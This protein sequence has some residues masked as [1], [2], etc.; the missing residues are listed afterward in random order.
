MKNI[1][2]AITNNYSNIEINQTMILSVLIVTLILSIYE[3]VVYR[4]ISHRSFYNKSF[5][6]CITILPL[7]LSTIIMCLQ[8]NII[9]TLGTIGALA[10]IRFRT[11]IK[12]PVDMLY[13]LW[14]IHIGITCGCRLYEVAFL[15]SIVVTIALVIL[16]RVTLGR[17][18]YIIVMHSSDE[19][20]IDK[21]IGKSTKRYRVKSRNYTSKGIDYTIEISTKN[22]NILL[23]SIKNEKN[24][25]KFSIIEY[26]ASDIL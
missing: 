20:E 19:V 4:Y 8:S 21:V 7:F 26:D 10:I 12:D 25:E 6:I 13:I 23:D 15:T 14:S 1:I 9:I 18:P 16:E 22:M 2:E 11:A 3:F 17:R 5:N 24:I